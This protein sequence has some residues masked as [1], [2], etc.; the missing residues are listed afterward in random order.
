MSRNENNG[1]SEDQT[2]YVIGD[3]S[4]VD[5]TLAVSNEGEDAFNSYVNFTLQRDFFVQIQ[6][7]N[8]SGWEVASII[9]T[10]IFR[11]QR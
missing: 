5:F 10:V 4:F 3:S 2:K 9:I 11:H 6:S 7:L 8:V 1:F